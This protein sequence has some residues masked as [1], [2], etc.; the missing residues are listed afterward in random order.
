[1]TTLAT[2]SVPA[3]WLHGHSSEVRSQ[4]HIYVVFEGAL[5]SPEPIQ[6]AT[7]MAEYASASEAKPGR[8]DALAKARQNLAGELAASPLAA[9]RLRAGLSQQQVAERMG[10]SQPQVARCEQSKHD[11]GT[12][13]IARLAQ[14]LGVSVSEVFDA[15]RDGLQRRATTQ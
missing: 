15:V 1:M 2:T 6:G 13:T 5:S 3:A 4:P 12:E 14:A 9:L 7:R 10:V 11:P 8:A